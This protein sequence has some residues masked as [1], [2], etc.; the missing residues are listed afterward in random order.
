M[1]EAIVLIIS[2]IL[3]VP[4]LILAKKPDAKAILDK[5]TPYQG[6]IGVVIFIWGIWSLITIL[7]NISLFLHISPIYLILFLAVAL[8]EAALGFILGFN[9]INTYVLSKNPKSEE[10]GQQLLA[11]LLPL[12]GKLGVAAIVLGVLT[13]VLLFVLFR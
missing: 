13:I 12:Q 1:L 8:V 10:K 9:L 4:S 5:V 6:W 7:L 2:G 11:K 3:A